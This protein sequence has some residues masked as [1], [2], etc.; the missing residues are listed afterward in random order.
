M[1]LCVGLGLQGQRCFA[2]TQSSNDNDKVVALCQKGLDDD[3][4]IAKIK[5]S[6]WIFQLG[7]DDLV[8]LKKAGVP[9]KV[10][11]AMLDASVISEARVSVDGNVVQMQTLGQAKIGGRLGSALT[12]GIKSVKE[13]AFLSGPKAAVT[14]R[15]NSPI[16]MV[17]LPK[18]ET[19]DSYIIVQMDKKD[20][21]REL[22]VGSVGG[23]VGA[24]T[25]IRAEAIQ[26]ATATPNGDN[27]FK[28]APTEPLKPG[29]YIVYVV[30]SADKVK[31][32]YGKGYDFSVN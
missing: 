31:E 14:A 12:Y 27:S 26:K 2:Q 17:S 4:V 6:S 3:I 21:R 9:S 28:L 5:A 30:G 32:I 13:K 22:E 25:G 11:A 15:S 23:V 16:I 1:I 10:V 20:D 19:I 24:K 8:A 7:D 29:E 18:G